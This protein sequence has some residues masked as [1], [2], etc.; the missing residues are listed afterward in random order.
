M[1]AQDLPVKNGPKVGTRVF[2]D[3][4][5]D[6]IYRFVIEEKNSRELAAVHCRV[7]KVC[8]DDVIKRARARRAFKESA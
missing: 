3:E 7:S 6:L 2:S 1:I 8:I 4:G 5:E